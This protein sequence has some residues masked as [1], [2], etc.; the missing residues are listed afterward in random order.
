[1]ILEIR[2]IHKKEE[3]IYTIGIVKDVKIH[4]RKSDEAEFAIFSLE[5]LDGYD[6]IE[7]RCFVPV[8]EKYK[9]LIKENRKILINAI[10]CEDENE[11]YLIAIMKNGMAL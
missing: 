7:C 5:S 4:K 10:C 6:A 11:I 1:M 9:Y 8:Y 2:D 3:N